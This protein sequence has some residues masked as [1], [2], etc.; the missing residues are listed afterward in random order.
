[1]RKSIF[2]CL[3]V[4][5]FLISLK[6]QDAHYSQ[7]FEAP[8]ILN[9]ALT[10]ISEGSFRLGGIYRNQWKTI[11]S[12]YENY[13]FYFDKNNEK[14]SYGLLLNQNNTGIEG[15]KT[16]NLLASFSLKK[17]LQ[18]GNNWLSFG[19]QIGFIQQRFDLSKM[20]FNNQYNSDKGFDSSLEHGEDF[21]KTSILLPDINVGLNWHFSKQ[22]SLP[23]TGD[24]GISFA[25]VNNPNSSFLNE[26]I[27]IPLKTTFYSRAQFD[28]K[29]NFGIEPFFIFSR[30]GTANEILLS[31]NAVFKFKNSKMKFGVGNRV[32]D[33]VILMASFQYK[34]FN[35]GFSYD[36]H[37]QDFGSSKK[38][39]SMELSMA[40]IF[41]LKVEET[42]TS[43]DENNE[44]ESEN[45]N[46]FQ[47]ENDFD[48]DGILNDLD[49]CPYESGLAKFEG[50]NDR[51][52]DDVWDYKDACPSLP[53]AIENY[54]C[55]YQNNNID[56]DNDGVLDQ[57]DDCIYVK[58]AANMNGCPDSDNDGL[59][60]YVDA[61]PYLKG[62]KGSNGCPINNSKTNEYQISN[63]FIEFNTNTSKILSKYYPFLD[64]IAFQLKNN[65]AL[66]I[67]IEG[68]TDKEGNH[69]FN[70]HLSQQRAHIVRNYFYEKGVPLERV[71]MHS[72]GET[73]PKLDRE[74]DFAK[75]RNRRVELIILSQ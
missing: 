57:Y 10:G 66:K 44:V 53:G 46:L 48:G 58:G 69:L 21:Q 6:S 4:F 71:E 49:K 40:Y 27:H 61:C 26:N 67:V 74:T 33:A 23:I 56:S 38:V 39:G 31:L 12:P 3:F 35:F 16:T 73:K 1:M 75:A 18:K 54:G 24:L 70:Y 19:S 9:S 65:E 15:L 5:I 34:N 2:S 59:S 72:Y 37:S 60:D 13:N 30:Q 41:G 68:H 36:A 25:H 20:T 62:S 22:T 47:T 63:D 50:C 51:D 64:R 7:T 42:D 43:F 28:I 55:P 45:E 32:K 8:L 52:G 11:H 14:F 29:N 17:R